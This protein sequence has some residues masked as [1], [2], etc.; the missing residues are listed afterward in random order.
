MEGSGKRGCGAVKKRTQHRTW[1]C[2]FKVLHQVRDYQLLKTDLC[3][4]RGGGTL[5]SERRIVSAPPPPGGI[6]YP[7]SEKTYCFPITNV[8]Q[9][10]LLVYCY[11]H[12]KHTNTLC[13]QNVVSTQF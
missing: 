13:Q 3:T 4:V 7:I 9:L 11:N 10:M 12:T 1:L 6:F 5:E 8:N 2:A